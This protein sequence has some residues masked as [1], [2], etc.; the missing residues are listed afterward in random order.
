MKSNIFHITD[1]FISNDP[2]Y[3]RI[4]IIAMLNQSIFAFAN[5]RMYTHADCAEES[6]VVF[7][8]FERGDRSKGDI[9]GVF[10]EKGWN[11]PIGTAI[12]DKKEGIV[13]LSYYRWWPV[14]KSK[15]FV[16]HDQGRF[17]ATIKDYGR[18]CDHTPEIVAPNRKNCRGHSHGASQAVTL[19]YGHKKGRQVVPARF[20]T[21]P[22]EDIKNLQENHYNCALY[23]DDQGNTW[24]NSEPVQV[25]TGEGCLVELSDGRIYYNSRAYFFDGKRRNGWSYDGGETFTDFGI[26]E[27][28]IEPINGGCNAGMVLYPPELTDGKDIILFS[29]P[30]AETRER[31]TIRASFDGGKSWP[32]SKVIH[33]GPAAYSAMTVAD[34]ETIFVLFENGDKHPYERISLASFKLGW[35]LEP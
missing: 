6:H 27:Q 30:A 31:M 7:R 11:A 8:R 15:D 24:Q 16:D 34:D 25:G 35:L 23:S 14:K 22:G 3:Y 17:I 2:E 13:H 18:Q 12:V 19:R 20:F 28:L 4:P 5:R 29:N 21:K 9:S 33:D 10:E 32:A 26:D 1:I